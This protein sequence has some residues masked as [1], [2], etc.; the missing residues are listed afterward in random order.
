[1]LQTDDYYIWVGAKSNR[2]LRKTAI[3]LWKDEIGENF[4]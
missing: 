2:N 3:F 4:A 1:M